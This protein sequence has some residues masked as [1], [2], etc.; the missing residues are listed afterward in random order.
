[1]K[2]FTP[3]LVISDGFTKNYTRFVIERKITYF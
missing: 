1:M 3:S 2:Y